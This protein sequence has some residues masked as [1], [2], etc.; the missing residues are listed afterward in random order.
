MTREIYDLLATVEKFF[1]VEVSI[2]TVGVAR[3]QIQYK[4][5]TT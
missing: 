5:F 2:L 3:I 4:S 1:I